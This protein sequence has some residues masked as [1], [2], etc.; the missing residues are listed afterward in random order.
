MYCF[1]AFHWQSK[2]NV[3]QV[4]VDDMVLLS[5]LNEEAIVENLRKRLMA[6]S[7]F[8]YIGP[9]LIS[10]NPFKEM[11]YFTEREMEIYQGAA[12]YENPP[13]IYALADNMF[14]NMIIDNENQCVIISGESG[15]GKTVD[16]KYIMS[17]ISRISGGGQRVQH[18]KDVILQS[19]PLLESFGNSATV[20]NW[21]SSRFGKYV[22]IVFSRGGEPIGGKISNFLLEK[23]RVVYQNQGERNFHIFYQLCAGADDSLKN[24]LGIGSLDYYNYLNHSGCYKIDGTDDARDFKQTL[25]AM[26][27]IGISNEMQLEVLQLVAAIMHIGNITFVEQNNYAAVY[28]EQFLE[29]PAFL[30]GLTTS[31]IKE[32]L[33]SRHMESKWGRQTEQID[34]TLNVQQAEFTRDAWVKELYAR[35]FDFLI[36]SVNEGMKVNTRLSGT[37]LS[38]GILDIY[39]FEIF[40][41]NGFEQFCINFVNEKLQQIFIELT[42]KA[43]QEEYVNEGIRWNEID[44]FNNKVVCDL[45]E[46]RK[47]PGIMCILDDTCSQIH[48]QSEGADSKFLMKLNQ[49]L[50]T[51][52][53]Y[54]S[55]AESFVIR[56]YAGE[57]VY[58]VDCFCEKNRD[59]LYQDLISLMQQSQRPFLVQMFPEMVSSG[60]KS[61][62][63]SFSSKIRTQ[64]NDLVESLTK[65]APHYVRCIKPN[66]TKR[67]LDWDD[68]RVLH[69][70]EYLGLKENIRVRRAGFAYRRTFERFIYRYAILSKET[71]PSYHG[72]PRK[73]IQIICRSVNMDADQY[74]LGKTKIF[75]KNPES[76][77]FYSV[78]N[79]LIW[80]KASTEWYIHELT[81]LSFI[82]ECKI[83]FTCHV[84]QIFAVFRLSYGSFFFQLFLL[85][86]MRER[87]YDGYARI[88]QKAFRKFN[89]QKHYMKVKEQACDLLYGRKERRRYSINRNF[90]GD[91]VGIE[92]HPAL[93]MLA[94]KRERII[95]AAT[96]SKY[97]RR[98]KTS[99]LDLLVTSKELLLIGRELVKSGPNKGKLVEVVKRTIGYNEL[100]SIGLSPYQDNF[101][102]LNVRDSYTSLLET[103]LKTEFVTAV[104]KRYAQLTNGAVLPLEFRNSYQIVLKKTRFGGGVRTVMFSLNPSGSDSTQLVPKGKTLTVY[105]GPGLPT[106]SRPSAQRTTIGG[107]KMNPTRQTQPH[108]AAPSPMQ[109]APPPAPHHAGPTSSNRVYPAQANGNV[110]NSNAY[111]HNQNGIAGVP[112]PF[113]QAQSPR[114]PKP[115]VKPKPMPLVEALYPYEAQDTDELSFAVGDKFELIN[116]GQQLIFIIPEDLSLEWIK[117]RRKGKNISIVKEELMKSFD[118]LIEL[119]GNENAAVFF[120]N[121]SLHLHTYCIDAP[122]QTL[123]NMSQEG[124]LLA[125]LT[126]SVRSYFWLLKNS[127]SSR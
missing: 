54:R 7:I 124:L 118:E 16:A 2:T 6:N 29:F 18:V 37:P 39:G 24:N 111:R 38:I 34:V 44:Y 60:A 13:H 3:Q 105:I 108:R 61:K 110:A 9:V 75:I 59:V 107:Y 57:V 83:L 43:E 12:Q 79:I 72:D 82:M 21:N 125:N 76:V 112:S 84:K 92:Y 53:H 114:K 119:C 126:F 123:Q 62:P 64:A 31:A 101:F 94:G 22:E 70:V 93:Q 51:N 33:T 104:S 85:E 14:R 30:L 98:F 19:N 25:H 15:A 58:N 8:T 11:P 86:E 49:L 66:E 77:C 88:I 80:L 71:W 36:N 99:K 45:I 67:P 97:D 55:G 106:N 63:T 26:S 1:Q 23:S 68:K 109:H 121:E 127:I 56:H 4:G 48:G 102:V 10:V 90:V 50:S 89:A 100:L 40:D 120:N 46:G 74:Q 81:L 17:Y 113:V 116:K 27:V 41:N 87:K 78:F 115:P 117:S 122:R 35:L 47:P 73:G 20:R 103:P 32:K 28:D 95:F 96:V 65:C 42:L 69:Q 91:Y 52:E 5:K